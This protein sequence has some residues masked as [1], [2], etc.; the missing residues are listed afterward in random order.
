MAKKCDTFEELLAEAWCMCV[1][2]QWL[3]ASPSYDRFRGWLDK[4][5]STCPRDEADATKLRCALRAAKECDEKCFAELLRDDYCPPA[6]NKRKRPKD[7]PIQRVAAVDNTADCVLLTALDTVD[8]CVGLQRFFREVAVHTCDRGAL[9]VRVTGELLCDFRSFVDDMFSNRVTQIGMVLAREQMSVRDRYADLEGRTLNRAQLALMHVKNLMPTFVW[10]RYATEK[11]YL[12]TLVT[13]LCP[14]DAHADDTDADDIRGQS[15]LYQLNWL[16]SEIDRTECE[17][18][19]LK[20]QH[21]KFIVELA[22]I[23]KKIAD[24][25]CQAANDMAA[26]VAELEALKAKSSEQECT[27]DRLMETIHISLH[28]SKSDSSAAANAASAGRGK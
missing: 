17:N 13:S 3:R 4:L 7:A 23:N 1:D 2:D 14:E 10:Q 24:V 9:L 16:R 11:G 21:S 15:L 8:G 22:E 18:H 26:K 5:S 12:K 20:E 25:Q 19:G 27:I 28:N 6:A